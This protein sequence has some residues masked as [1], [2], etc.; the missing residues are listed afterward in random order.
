MISPSVL[1]WAGIVFLGIAVAY[2]ALCL[3]WDR[4]SH[5]FC[6]NAMAQEDWEKK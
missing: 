4:K 6:A 1:N 5:L 3:A 2:W